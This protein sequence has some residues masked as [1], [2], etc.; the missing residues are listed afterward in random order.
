M[1]ICIKCSA[2][3]KQFAVLRRL[4]QRLAETFV[5]DIFGINIDTEAALINAGH[6]DAD[7][8]DAYIR[9]CENSGVSFDLFDENR[10]FMQTDKITYEKVFKNKLVLKIPT[11]IFASYNVG[12]LITFVEE[13]LKNKEKKYDSTVEPLASMMEIKT[14]K[15]I[16]AVSINANGENSHISYRLYN[17]LQEIVLD[18]NIIKSNIK[19]HDVLDALDTVVLQNEMIDVISIALP[20]VMVEGNVYSGIIEGG[21]HQLKELLEKRYEKEIYMINDVNAAVVGYYASQN[22]Y[23]S[24]VFFIPTYWTYGWKWNYCQ[25][26]TSKR[27]DHLAGEVA[28]LPLNLSEDYLTLANTPRRHIGNLLV[29]IL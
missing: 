18:S 26:S 24:I 21:N 25:W 4:Q 1:L 15:N 5:M 12:A 29:K 3:N 10:P 14:K 27:M 22:Q 8:I 11:Q 13:S 19:L 6:F 17:N 2:E 7:E 23:K 28:L 16:L 9:N 20:G